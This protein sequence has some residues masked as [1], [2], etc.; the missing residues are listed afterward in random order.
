MKSPLVVLA[1]AGV[2]LLIVGGTGMC[3]RFGVPET[4]AKLLAAYDR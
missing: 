2:P 3:D 1:E 4:N